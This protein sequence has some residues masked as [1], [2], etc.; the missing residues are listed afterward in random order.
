L[1]EE[2]VK[3]ASRAVLRPSHYEKWY[4]R[5]WVV[6]REGRGVAEK[7]RVM[8]KECWKERQSTDEETVR[9][10]KRRLLLLFVAAGRQV[11]SIPDPWGAERE[12][13]LEKVHEELKRK[14][15]TGGSWRR[16][17]AA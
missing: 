9:P 14:K 4:K 7:E 15:G 13:H 1:R 3:I 5:G 6:V 16:S 2:K 10:R 12:A 17:T 11:A 8:T